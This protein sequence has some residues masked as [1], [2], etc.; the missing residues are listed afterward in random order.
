MIA[1]P[2]PRALLKR[3]VAEDLAKRAAVTG[4]AYKTFKIHLPFGRVL[5]MTIQCT[6]EPQEP[7][8]EDR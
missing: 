6:V 7:S 2:T 5:E 1:I 8:K 3:S 4:T